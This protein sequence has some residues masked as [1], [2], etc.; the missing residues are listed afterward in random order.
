[1]DYP[2]DT[3]VISNA[4]AD[5]FNISWHDPV[6]IAEF[7]NVGNDRLNKMIF[8]WMATL[9]EGFMDKT[10][11][12][13][14]ANYKDDKYPWDAKFMLPGAPGANVNMYHGLNVVTACYLIAT[15]LMRV[16]KNAGADGEK[17]RTKAR[18]VLDYAGGTINRYIRT[19]TRQVSSNVLVNEIDTADRKAYVH[20][21]AIP[22]GWK[23]AVALKPSWVRSSQVLSTMTLRRSTKPAINWTAPGPAS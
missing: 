4:L 8:D 15:S 7:L 9:P 5:N 19:I 14:F 13:V 11:H 16:T 17:I 1:M 12:G 21:P 3:R 10:F 22:L 20:E 18:E 23:R 6:K 2:Y